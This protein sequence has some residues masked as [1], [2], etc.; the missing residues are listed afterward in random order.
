MKG[1]AAMYACPRWQK[2][3]A[4]VCPLDPDWHLR[5]HQK[6]E[7]VCFYLLEAVKAGSETR[8]KGCATEEL[9]LSV[10]APLPEMVS[11]WGAIKRATERA[12]SS[13]SRMDRVPP[14][15]SE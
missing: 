4:N 3:G 11:R 12:K 2:C 8:F 13:G 14:G 10:L 6:G 7:P 5:S 9:R 1:E 15:R